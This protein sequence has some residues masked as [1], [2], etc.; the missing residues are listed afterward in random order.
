MHL[1]KTPHEYLW[2][3]SIRT[4][5]SCQCD[6]PAST[7]LPVAPQAVTSTTHGATSDN[8]VV[9]PT[10]PS[11]VCMYMSRINRNNDD[12]YSCGINT[13][14]ERCCQCD[15]PAS[16]GGMLAVCL[17][18]KS[19]CIYYKCSISTKHFMIVSSGFVQYAIYMY[20]KTMDIFVSLNY[21]NIPM[22]NQAYMVMCFLS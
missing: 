6:D 10:D 16:T 9:T 2:D 19:L 3:T 15:D 4:G 5:R 21:F 14:T 20:V 7:S 17:Q 12:Q 13:R 18:C 1:S 11:T 22:E 8:I